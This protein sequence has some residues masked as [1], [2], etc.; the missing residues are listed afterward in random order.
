M[1]ADG[2]K[3]LT[4]L[5][6]AQSAAPEERERSLIGDCLNL[7]RHELGKLDTLLAGTSKI[8]EDRVYL[9]VSSLNKGLA[10][11]GGEWQRDPELSRLK[12]LVV[13]KAYRFFKETR[14]ALE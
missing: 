3:L 14:P 6:A 7:A 5:T 9:T 1:P 4:A 12:T 13:E 2:Q 11:I 8:P 10:E